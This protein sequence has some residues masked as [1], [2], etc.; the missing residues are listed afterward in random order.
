MV[1]TLPCYCPNPHRPKK[2]SSVIFLK[3]DVD[4][5]QD[6][7]KEWEI[8]AMPTLLFLKEGKIIDK[9]AGA[10]KDELIDKVAKHAAVAAA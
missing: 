2:N 3:V 1:M 4:E 8:E 9:I 7:A 10:K 6:V 5:L